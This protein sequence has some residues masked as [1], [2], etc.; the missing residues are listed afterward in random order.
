MEVLGQA[1]DNWSAIDYVLYKNEGGGTREGGLTSLNAI[2]LPIAR[3]RFK[4][5]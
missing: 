3:S 1:K 5:R 4:Q 2:F